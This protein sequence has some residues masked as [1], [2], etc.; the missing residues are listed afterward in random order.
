MGLI[1]LEGLQ[2]YAYH[3]VY[4]E[5]S[6]IG[7]QYTIDVY[8][9]TSFQGAAETDDV[10]QTINYETVFLVCQAEMRK[11]VKLIETLAQ[12]IIWALK[13][14]FNTIQEVKIRIGKQNP[15]PHAKLKKVYVEENDSFLQQCPRCN[16]GFLCYGDEN[17]WCQE[18]QI[19]SRTREQL[20]EQFNGCLCTNCLTFYAG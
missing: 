18:V 7:N 17:C 4:E 9:E 13:H 5:E 12:N 2:F 19:H 6:L 8:I 10:S 3:G 11:P 20:R 16:G 1:A 15:L 14:Q